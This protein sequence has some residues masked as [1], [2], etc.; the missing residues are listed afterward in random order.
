MFR[1]GIGSLLFI[2]VLHKPLF[3]FLIVHIHYICLLIIVKKFHTLPPTRDGE[4]NDYLL[5]NN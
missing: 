5:S 2:G 3:L 4:G 1:E